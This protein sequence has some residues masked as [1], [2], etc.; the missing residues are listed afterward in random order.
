MQSLDEQTITKTTA[1]QCATVLL[2]VMPMIMQTLHA[3]RRN[4]HKNELSVPQFRGLIFIQN[5]PEASLS[6]VGD[7]LGLTL[8]SMSKIID[9]LVERQLLTRGQH[10][11]D[12]RRLHLALTPFGQ[13]LLTQ[14]HQEA[15]LCL[16]R[17]LDPCPE[18]DRQSIYEALNLLRSIF[19]PE[20]RTLSQTQVGAA[21]DTPARG[22]P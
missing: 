6:D 2:E 5:N 1:L 18:A 11:E 12:R 22:N 13:D 17:L 19:R 4:N 10:P 7:F 15:Q 8:P 21:T 3:H 9:G 14:T 16:S 20:S